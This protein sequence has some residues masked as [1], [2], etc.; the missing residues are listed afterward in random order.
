MDILTFHSTYLI[1]EVTETALI[2]K[3]RQGVKDSL[4]WRTPCFNIFEVIIIVVLSI[5]LEVGKFYINTA[6]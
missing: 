3:Y 2:S 6:E 1:T 4:T 5:L